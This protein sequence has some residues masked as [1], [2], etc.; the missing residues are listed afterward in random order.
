M[1]YY[2]LKNIF[3]YGK[4]SISYPF[5][6]QDEDNSY[7]YYTPGEVGMPHILISSPWVCGL[8]NAET[9]QTFQEVISQEQVSFMDQLSIINPKIQV[10][11]VPKKSNRKMHIN[12]SITCDIESLSYRQFCFYS[13]FTYVSTENQYGVE[14]IHS[15]VSQRFHSVKF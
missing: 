9:F 15:N 3:P 5:V 2:H 1:N 4:R 13:H 11:N 10:L 7:V 12:L 8:Y 14:S 6:N